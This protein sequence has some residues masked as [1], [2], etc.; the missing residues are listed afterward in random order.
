MHDGDGGMVDRDKRARLALEADRA[1]G[2]AAQGRGQDFDRD[3]ALQ[4][5]IAGAIPLAHA[6]GPDRSG[7]LVRRDAR[8]LHDGHDAAAGII[9]GRARRDR[10]YLPPR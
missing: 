5:G 6:A 9:S 1:I 10:R 2:V 4:A 3:V 8:A 7:D